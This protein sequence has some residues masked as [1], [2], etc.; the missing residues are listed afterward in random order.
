MHPRLLLPTLAAALVV[1]PSPAAAA[2]ARATTARFEVTSDAGAEEARGAARRLERLQDVLERL[3]P[4]GGDPDAPATPVLL[5]RDGA[6]FRALV[7]AARNRA[8]DVA[9]FV[10]SGSDG[11]RAVVWSEPTGAAGNERW[12]TLD[13]E[14]VHLQLGRALPAQP[15][16]LAEGLAE[17]LSA[18][19]IDEP[20]ARLAALGPGRLQSLAQSPRLPVAQLVATDWESTTYRGSAST[21][22]FYSGALALVRRLLDDHG[23][24]ALLAMAGALATAGD[25]QAAFEAA[26]G[27]PAAL[28]TALLA[29]SPGPLLRVPAG[30]VAAVAIAEATPT[31]A[32]IEAILGEILLQGGHS[33]EARRRFEAALHDDPAAAHA[34]LAQVLLQEGEW[35]AARLELRAA[36][37][38]RPDEPR[39]LLR[40]AQLLLAAARNSAEG[41]TAPVEAEAIAALERA[42]ALDPHLVEA[43]CLLA[44]EKPE[45]VV[46]RIELLA[47]AFAR[48]PGRSDVGLTLAWLYGKRNDVEAARLVLRRSRDAAR[49]GTY[50]F[51]CDRQLSQLGAYAR[52]TASAHGRLQ[53]LECRRDGSLVLTLATDAG[54]LRLEAGSRRSFFVAGGEDELDLKC[55]RQDLPVRVRYSPPAAPGMAG[56]L[57]T[58]DPWGG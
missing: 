42:V 54:P 30:P 14:L 11:P 20:E 40:Q 57:L 29:V 23:M 43:L 53:R 35:D 9:G 48:D 32:E 41:L 13:H 19:E 25:A 46:R 2:W 33:R 45:P 37:A 22:A 7:P 51:L 56:E 31:Q 12:R 6:T 34:G 39:L 10:L 16:W 1:L 49:D 24:E 8:G 17:A 58:L 28:D 36:V 52:A 44:H 27:P 3:L 21:T 4:A 50:R 26:F 18:G 55:G 38:A 47:R 5:L 15:A